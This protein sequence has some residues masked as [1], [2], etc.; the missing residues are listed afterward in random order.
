MN[1]TVLAAL[2]T[3]AA[4][5]AVFLAVDILRPETRNATFEAESRDV[6]PLEAI[7][8]T[9]F[10]RAKGV[11]TITEP[12]AHLRLP[13]K[14]MLLGKQLVIRPRFHLDEGDVLEVGV[15]KTSFWLD[16]DR[17]PLQ[18]RLLDVLLVRDENTWS[19]LRSGSRIAYLNSRFDN[20]W[21]TL[22]EF[23]ERLPTDGTIG[24][25]GNAVLPR[26]EVQGPRPA[27]H[28]FRVTDDPDSFRAIYAFYPDP[29]RRDPEWTE[30]AQRFDLARAYQN[31]DGS[32]EI[33]FFVQRADG[34]AI[35]VLMDDIVF[36]VEPGWPRPRD[37]VAQARRS[38]VRLL[39][40]PAVRAAL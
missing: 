22:E 17:L 27:V 39:R 11:A 9:A 15:K 25:Y 35:R 29:S 32:I 40:R 4:G 7:N 5:S 37:L 38:I 30:N 21:Q 31:E 12:L 36:R 6:G 20:P 33:M 26:P 18:H 10:P 3:V 23:E 24:L 13:L 14:R 34:G 2:L 19:A 16:Y 28:P 1:Q 8:G